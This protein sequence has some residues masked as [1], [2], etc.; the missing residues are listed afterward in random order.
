MQSEHKYAG[1]GEFVARRLPANAVVLA[2]QQNDLARHPAG[3]MRPSIEPAAS[4]YQPPR[5][6][7][8]P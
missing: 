3:T 8:P 1:V 2:M 4:R 7:D 5:F 6:I